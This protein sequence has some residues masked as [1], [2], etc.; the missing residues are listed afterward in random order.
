[1]KPT[2][3][4]TTRCARLMLGTVLAIAC[5]W[6]TRA[7]AGAQSEYT[8][9]VIA[10]VTNCFSVA[11]PVVNNAG[12]VAFGASCFSPVGPPGGAVVI[13]RGS[14]GLLTDIFTLGD[15]SPVGPH[16]DVLSINDAG[17]VAF[18]GTSRTCTGSAASAILTGDGGSPST[19]VDTCNDPRYMTV[20]RPSINNDGAVAF[21]ADTDGTGGYDSV[22]VVSGG[23]HTTVA[24][25]GT[26]TNSVG[27]LSA[28]LEP[29]INNNGLVT[30][31]GQGLSTFGVFTGS[32]GAVTTI[33][34]DNPST[35]NG[36]NDAGRVAFLGNNHGAIQTGDGGPLTTVATLNA[37]G[38]LNFSGVA[39]IN[40]SGTA[41]FMAT[42]Q[43]GVGVFTGAD[44]QADAVLKVGDVIPEFGTV[45]A[46]TSSRE[47]IN[48]SGQVAIAVLFDQEGAR[49]AAIIRADPPNRP[50]VASDGAAS[51]AAGDSVSGTLS[52]TDPDGDSLTYAI[53]ANGSQGTA[54]I[55]DAATGAF[56]YTANAGASGSDA[57]TFQV[58]DGRGMASNV[59]TMSIDIQPPVCAADV[60]AS[61]SVGFGKVSKRAAQNTRKIT[62]RNMS[63]APIAG[64]ISLALDALTP[65]VS[66]VGATGVT[67]CAGPAGSLYL[68]VDVG[69]DNVFSRRERVSVT[70][71]FSNAGGGTVSFIPR[72]LA[73]P[74]SR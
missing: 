8:Y 9:T 30:F 15:F 47:A 17:V 42:I 16:I 38:Y 3:F 65:G 54:A 52:G 46:V 70:L 61:I 51:V 60:T 32:G 7:P 26:V 56:T 44:P 25:P 4:R 24:G 71:E 12:E 22:I 55:T 40:A 5:F 58:T 66:L 1:M 59:A 68:D 67:S 41:G 27:T 20:L 73:G 57:F 29:S 28:A 2:I 64:P 6:L 34:T 21:M 69:A 39:A 74:G 11:S 50:P 23:T 62:L 19:L 37:A 10:D 43:S 35:F 13:R 33:S 14:G 63:A 49:R 36:I 53:V 48:D 18:A 72:I 45:T 31:M